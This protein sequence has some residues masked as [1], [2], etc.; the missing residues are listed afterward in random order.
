MRFLWFHALSKHLIVYGLAHC[1]GFAVT[2]KIS[3]KQNCEKSD[4]KTSQAGVEERGFRGW[5]ARFRG[6]STL[7]S[8]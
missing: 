6:C 1:L 4:P 7:C 2:G 5:D 3:R 8:P